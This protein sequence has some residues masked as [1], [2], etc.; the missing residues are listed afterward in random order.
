MDRKRGQ[1]EG[2]AGEFFFFFFPVE[3][4]VERTREAKKTMAVVQWP[5]TPSLRISLSGARENTDLFQR[6]HLGSFFL[7]SRKRKR[8]RQTGAAEKMGKKRV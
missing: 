1:R 2:K 5:S 4:E 3:V 8:E 7:P 6:A